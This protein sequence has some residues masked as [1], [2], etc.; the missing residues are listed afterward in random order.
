[1]DQD[2]EI[3]ELLRTSRVIAVVG[4]SPDEGKASNIVARYL[5]GKGYKVIPVNPGAGSILGE[6][7]YKSLGDIDEKVDIV[8]IFMR[9]EKVLPFVRDALALKPRAVWLQLG[10]V[11]HEAK[12]LSE[13]QGVMFVMDRCVKQEHARLEPPPA[14]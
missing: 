12:A 9:A 7:S 6:K 8:D 5:M 11:S 4:L 1:M 10:I 13:E 14:P 2:R 3:K